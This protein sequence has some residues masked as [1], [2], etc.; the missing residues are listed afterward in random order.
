MNHKYRHKAAFVAAV[1]F[2]Q[3]AC[4]L[5]SLVS[6][7]GTVD[8]SQEEAAVRKAERELLVAQDN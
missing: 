2:L 4:F 1:L 3:G 6:A 5:P 7:A 8:T